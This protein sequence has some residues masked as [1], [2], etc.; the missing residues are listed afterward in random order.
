[1]NKMRKQIIAYGEM[2]KDNY[3]EALRLYRECIEEKDRAVEDVIST[4][5]TIQG[6]LIIQGR[7]DKNLDKIKEAIGECI[8]DLEITG[9]YQEFYLNLAEA[10]S[11]YMDL[12]DSWKTGIKDKMTKALYE[13]W[14]LPT[15]DERKAGEIPSEEI[16]NN[17]TKYYRY[18]LYKGGKNND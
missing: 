18:E 3:E 16:I 2:I 11:A 10:Y 13:A 15:G 14:K 17:R 7:K 4:K 5:Q 9:K 6:I 8:I 1:M 12:T